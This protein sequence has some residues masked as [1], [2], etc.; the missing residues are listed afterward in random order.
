V[1]KRRRSIGSFIVYPNVNV[2]PAIYAALSG[3]I[4]NSNAPYPGPPCAARTLALGY[5]ISPLQGWAAYWRARLQSSLACDRQSL[6]FGLYHFSVGELHGQRRVRVI[7]DNVRIITIFLENIVHRV[8]GS[9]AG[10]VQS[11]V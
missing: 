5:I 10:V 1:M 9:K 8:I 3:L 11:Q 4:K 6:A 7:V 2:V